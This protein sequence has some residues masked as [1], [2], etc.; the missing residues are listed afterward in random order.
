LSEAAARLTSPEGRNIF[1]EEVRMAVQADSEH[2][3][4]S[5]RKRKLLSFALADRI[6]MLSRGS[7]VADGTPHELK[8]RVASRRIRCITSIPAATVEA[9]DGVSS[10]R[11]DGSATEILTSNAELVIR[12]LL[13]R[14][15]A[16]S[17]LETSGAGLE[18]AFLRLT[19]AGSSPA[20]RSEE[21]TMAAAGGV[22]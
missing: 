14:D 2:G 21:R 13:L 3:P 22:R 7:I 19:T 4:G 6:V 15:P 18:D 10:V 20:M 9:L 11:R 16:L 1:V 5:G 12:Q 8:A 17:G